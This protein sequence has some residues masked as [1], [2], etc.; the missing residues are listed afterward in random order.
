M[1]A[2][3]NESSNDAATPDPEA[4]SRTLVPVGAAWLAGTTLLVS[5]LA[6]GVGLIWFAHVAMR[7]GSVPPF[8][9]GIVALTGGAG[10]IEVALQ[11]LESGRGQLLLVSGVSHGVE[12]TELARRAGVDPEPLAS[13]VTMGRDARS[14]FGNAI[15]TASW[16]RSNNLHSLIVVTAGYHMPRALTEIRRALPEVR[17]YPDPVMPPALRG[18]RGFS[19]ARLLA[20]EYT[21]WL[22][23]QIWRVHRPG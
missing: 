22:L 16:A 12:F 11:L 20:S 14:T 9:D 3:T 2:D 23:V 17:L 5:A 19:R 21:K 1:K 7:P 4:L 18:S 8:A 10:R 13:R 6:W 15:E